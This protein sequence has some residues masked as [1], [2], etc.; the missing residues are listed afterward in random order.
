MIKM[1]FDNFW[2]HLVLS[3]I[4]SVSFFALLNGKPGISF[5]PTHGLRER[6]PL[7]PY[8][9]LIIYDAL[10]Q[11]LTKHVNDAVIDEIK[12]GRGGLTLFHFFFVDDVFSSSRPKDQ[13]APN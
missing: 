1:G 10:S 8:L 9:F 6:N 11:N 12:L 5:S 13:T 7:S 4:S 2:I 3:C